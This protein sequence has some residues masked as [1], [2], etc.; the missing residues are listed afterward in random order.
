MAE[1]GAV[2]SPFCRPSI[3]VSPKSQMGYRQ[4]QPSHDLALFCML[5]AVQ[6]RSLTLALRKCRFCHCRLSTRRRLEHY[7]DAQLSRSSTVM[8]GGPVNQLSTSHAFRIRPTNMIFFVTH[9]FACD[10]RHGM[11]QKQKGPMSPPLN[12]ARMESCVERLLSWSA[13]RSMVLLK[14]RTRPTHRSA[15]CGSPASMA[16]VRRSPSKG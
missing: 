16:F 15:D 4:T 10:S 2:A 6:R 12:S 5:P 8:D 7:V 3:P 11:G 14:L 9:R 1:C 13:S